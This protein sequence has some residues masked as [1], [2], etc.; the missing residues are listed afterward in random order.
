MSKNEL[1]KDEI[2]E[3]TSSI[4]YINQ[5]LYSITIISFD[6]CSVI[7]K[8]TSDPMRRIK[9]LEEFE[10][11]AVPTNIM[12]KPFLPGITDCENYIRS[13]KNLSTSYCVVG[14]LYTDEKILNNMLKNQF[15]KDYFKSEAFK[16]TGQISCIGENILDT[17]ND[18]II[19]SF[20]SRLLDN[21]IRVF[22]KST[23]VSANILKVNNSNRK[24]YLA[25]G[26]CVKCGN[27]TP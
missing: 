26:F 12:I 7:E 22:K 16:D 13:L 18:S 3:I 4:E 9:V 21:N 25:E 20:I 5:L 23:C 14:K 24:K 17:Y 11:R 19:D 2:E 6:F 8:G 27:C 1:T 15:F 10:K